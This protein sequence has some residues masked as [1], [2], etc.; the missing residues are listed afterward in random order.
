MDLLKVFR[1]LVSTLLFFYACAYAGNDI[2][3]KA[4]KTTYI[5]R[6]KDDISGRDAVEILRKY[7][8]EVHNGWK[9]IR[10]FVISHVEEDRIQSFQEEFKEQIVYFEE[11]H[12]VQMIRVPDDTRLHEQTGLGRMGILRP[13]IELLDPMTLS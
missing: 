11:D 5:V 9:Q 10:A 13:G 7:G 1:V 2:H 12:P 8:F 4:A 6:L 3:D